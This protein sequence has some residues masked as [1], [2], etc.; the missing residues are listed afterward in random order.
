MEKKEVSFDEFVTRITQLATATAK[1]TL[2]HSEL[3]DLLMKMIACA[4][5]KPERAEDFV[6]IRRKYDYIMTGGERPKD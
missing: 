1:Q 2:V 5:I 6:A 3:I 4:E